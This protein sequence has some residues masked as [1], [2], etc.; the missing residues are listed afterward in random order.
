MVSGAV[1]VGGGHVL[2]QKT[3][4]PKSV[5]E[6]LAYCLTCGGT[7]RRGGLSGKKLCRTCHGTGGRTVRYDEPKGTTTLDE[8]CVS[9]ENRK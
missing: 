5:S 8:S 1:T 3:P 6:K 9:G 7:G 2:S 4:N